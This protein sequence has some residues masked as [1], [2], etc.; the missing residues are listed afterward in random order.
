MM[1]IASAK[2]VDPVSSPPLVW[3]DLHNVAA[4]IKAWIFQNSFEILVALAIG[5]AL[6]LAF[7]L[8]ANRAGALARRRNNRF[9]LISIVLRAICKTG[10]FFML[11][12]AIRLVS[13]FAD[14]P[15]GVRSVINFLFIVAAAYQV[16]IWVRELILGLVERRAGDGGQD[17]SETLANAM[18]LI[19]LMVTII[20]FAIASIVVL[21]NVGV[22]VT[23]LIAGLGV[24]GIAI[25]LAAQG[26]FSDLF[27][28]LSIIFDKPFQRGDAIAFDDFGGSVE[29]IG[30]KST[31]IRSL[32]GEEIIIS[33]TK[34][35]DKEIRNNTRL[36]HRRPRFR[37]G[38]IYQTPP[39]VARAIPA[40]M[41]EV[42]EA[43]GATFVR[44]G[45]VGFGDSSIDFQLDFDVM[46]P[47][48]AVAFETTHRVGLAILQRFNE[49]GIEFAYPR[50]RRSRPRP[51]A[52]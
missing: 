30:L 52:R 43:N 8:I 20:L 29:K 10:H 15:P 40:I 44:C 37:I 16:A 32:T 35:L 49:E 46:S 6:Y 51:T 48:Y 28:A 13:G 41:Q 4:S 50:R 12:L 9:S 11:M 45:F 27:A 47:E 5:T 17:G 21:D 22:D 2:H 38:V 1:Q 36:A 33:N 14:T 7:V 23:G 42:V 39:D 24:G 26:I 18:T 3:S 31:R 19:N 25:G 34:L